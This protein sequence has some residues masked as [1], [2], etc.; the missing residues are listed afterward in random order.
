MEA[1]TDAKAGARAGQA[2]PSSAARNSTTA[3]DGKKNVT[4]RS[5]MSAASGSNDS[6]LPEGSLLVY[7]KG[8][9]VFRMPPAPGQG[10]AAASATGVNGT[11]V[12]G[13]QVQ[14][15]SSV[16]PAGVL[17]LSPEVA[18]GSLLYRVEPEYPEKARQRQMQG[19]VILDVRMGSDGTVQTVK[20]VRGQGLLAD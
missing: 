2:P 17:E 9:E 3:A 5:K 4:P 1:A 6:L 18:E 8:K 16:E 11:D 10:E 7:E 19:S 12:N 20:L 14:R 13:S 15:A